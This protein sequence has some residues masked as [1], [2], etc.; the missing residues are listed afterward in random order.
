MDTYGLHR[1]NG[2]ICWNCVEG[3]A[4]IGGMLKGECKVCDGTGVIDKHNPTEPE[5]TKLQVKIDKRS[6]NYKKL[7]A[8]GLDDAEIQ[9][10][11]DE[12]V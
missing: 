1:A 12:A 2:I 4:E 3:K 6:V 8:L 11:F 7:K 9:R 10:R 5:Q